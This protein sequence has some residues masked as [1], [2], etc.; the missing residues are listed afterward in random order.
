MEPLGNQHF[1]NEKCRVLLLPLKCLIPAI[2][3]AE[4]KTGVLLIE[5]F[6]KLSILMLQNSI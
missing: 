3:T 1:P 5:T 6:R 4:T 2:T